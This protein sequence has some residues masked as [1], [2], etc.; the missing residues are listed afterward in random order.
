M[1]EEA[2]PVS[3]GHPIGLNRPAQLLLQRK[4]E[5]AY[6]P[7]K[8]KRFSENSS[9]RCI[10]CVFARMWGSKS[11]LLKE[12]NGPFLCLCVHIT[13]LCCRV[14]LAPHGGYFSILLFRTPGPDGLTSPTQ[15]GGRGHISVW[16]R[17]SSFDQERVK[18]LSQARPP[19]A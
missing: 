4:Q 8:G 5:G 9:G 13:R 1:T 7:R 12:R 19:G 10:G 11:C 2:S 3:T 18:G 16:N 17:W 15:P 6:C 14:S